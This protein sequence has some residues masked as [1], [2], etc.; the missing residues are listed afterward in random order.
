MEENPSDLSEFEPVEFELCNGNQVKVAVGPF[1][2]R[3]TDEDR[4]VGV[5]P[6]QYLAIRVYSTEDVLPRSLALQWEFR[7]GAEFSVETIPKVWL[8]LRVL[9]ESR[10]Y[11]DFDWFEDFLAAFGEQISYLS[12]EEDAVEHIERLSEVVRPE[13]FDRVD[14]SIFNDQ[15]EPDAPGER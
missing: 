2:D 12:G 11:R 7:G 5:K 1:W 3:L 4:R 14:D 8:W 6:S 10:E 15:N 9:V 13:A